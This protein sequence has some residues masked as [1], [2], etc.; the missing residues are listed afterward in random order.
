MAQARTFALASLCCFLPLAPARAQVSSAP[1]APQDQTDLAGLVPATTRFYLSVPSLS[2]SWAG[3]C[4][5]PLYQAYCDEEVQAFLKSLGSDLKN[6]VPDVRWE[7]VEELLDL[8]AIFDGQAA[9]ALVDPEEHGWVLSLSS[10]GDAARVAAFA[11]H[12]TESLRR[13]FPAGLE[14]SEIAGARVLTLRG[15][16][17]DWNVATAPGRLLVAPR[18]A[19]LESVLSGADSGAASLAA[20]EA[21]QKGCAGQVDGATSFFLYVPLQRLLDDE[22][23]E[24]SKEDRDVLSAA[25]GEGLQ[26]LVAGLAMSEGR[27]NDL[28]RIEIAGERRG[29]FD[30]FVDGPIEPALARLAPPDTLLLGGGLLRIKELHQTMARIIRAS[31][32]AWLEGEER[33][34]EQL[35]EDVRE[36]ALAAVV[37]SLG[38]EIMLFV[39]L[40]AG[41]FIPTGALAVEVLRPDELQSDFMTLCS[42]LIGTEV[43][44]TSFRGRNISY[45]KPLHDTYGGFAPS[46]CVTDGY[47]LLSLHTSV[48]KEIIGRLDGGKGSLADDPAFRASWEK[49]PQKAGLVGY[50]NSKR[51]FEYLYGM[52]LSYAPILGAM[53]P[54]DAAMLPTAESISAYLSF[55]LTGLVADDR[56]LLLV[57][58]SDGYGP[59]STAMYV[60]AGTAAAYCLMT[61]E[62]TS[63]RS[64]CRHAL[65]RIHEDLETAR[66]ETQ[67]YPATLRALHREDEPWRD[68][69][70]P[71]ATRQR[72]NIG[73][74]E[75]APYAHF[76]YVLTSKGIEPPETFP[77]DWMIV[78]DSEPRHNNGRM[79]LC[80]SGEITWL[81]EPAFQ[82][83]LTEQGP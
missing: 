20:D 46:W 8:P 32:G 1:L 36:R 42:E 56:G 39:S 18:R 66:Q 29:F 7:F 64:D 35:A 77:D 2:R 82:Q 49:L 38:M 47:L 68:A 73:Q 40:P 3:F 80:G 11:E 60:L 79:V 27:A 10:T 44:T 23:A 16:A 43:K 15:P 58:E 45:S 25:G 26:S 75:E 14:T 31:R 67:H 57:T 17:C 41:G 24:A 78:W 70:C 55:G 74:G 63:H 83:R 30:L 69:H 37:D 34:G 51:L 61:D 76:A 71:E 50:A 59:T 28:V 53:F 21:F 54:V 6:N 22:L 52:L 33:P 48:L 13:V 9:F 19:H 12:L 65:T 72:T 4:T 62:F 81:P 5:L